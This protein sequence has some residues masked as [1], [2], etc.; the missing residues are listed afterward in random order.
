MSG[1]NRPLY[2]PTLRQMAILAALALLAL[3]YAFYLRYQLIEQPSVALACEAGPGSW[4]CTSR[5]ITVAL[6]TPMAFGYVAL[7]AALLNLLRPALLLWAVA[8][9][10]AG[11]G[12][13]LYNTALA[14]LAVAILMLSLAR[15]A[16]EPE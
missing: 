13:V 6:F 4:S 12:L 10:A 3:F 15:P 5:R 2:R 8:L 16:P 9:I 7:G 11:L 1:M 14:A